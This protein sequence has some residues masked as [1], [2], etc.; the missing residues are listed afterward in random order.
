MAGGDA[1]RMDHRIHA[2][3]ARMFC[4]VQV[5]NHRARGAWAAKRA[6]ATARA[7]DGHAAQFLQ[8]VSAD[9]TSGTGSASNI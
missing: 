3:S 1:G 9:E 4:G 2:P 6:D 8:Q 7:G 5:A